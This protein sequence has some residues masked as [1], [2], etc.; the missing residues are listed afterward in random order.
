M[1]ILFESQLKKFDEKGEKSSWTYITVPQVVSAK[2]N[3]TVK[4]SYRVKGL[5]DKHP[6]NFVAMVPMG[7]G[8]FIIA[9]NAEMRKA[10][11]KQKGDKVSMAL[12][13]DKAIITINKALLD[14]LADEPAALKEFNKMPPS[15]QHYYSKW[16]ESA[17]TEGTQTKRIAIAVD[18]L[19]KKMNYGEMIRSQ[20]KNK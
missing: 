12:E 3:P 20:A 7:N 18:T 17:K 16:I 4:K 13:L 19:S 6:I 9:I 11:R 1:K 8:E 5:I 2:L 10:I 14:C 15:H